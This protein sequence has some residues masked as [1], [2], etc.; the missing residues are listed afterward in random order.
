MAVRT[1]ANADSLS[2]TTNLPTWGT[3]T[4]M[5]WFMLVTDRN[6]ASTFY[7]FNTATQPKCLL[8]AGN[9]GVTLTHWNGTTETAGTTLSTGTWNHI[10]TTVNGTGSG[11]VTIYLNGVQDMNVAGGGAGTSSAWYIARSE[12][13]NEYIDGRSAAIKLWDAVLTVGE[14]RQEMPFYTPQR[15]TNI[16]GWYPMWDATSVATDQSPNARALTTAG[17]FATEDGPPI[18]WAPSGRRKIFT[19]TDAAPAVTEEFMFHCPQQAQLP[20]SVVCH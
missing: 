3:L 10:A 18:V 9:D 19:F 4:M 8:E 2:R 7:T 13:A 17:T 20:L 14:V 16:N 6:T 11:A 15:Q 1:D 5:G 12:A